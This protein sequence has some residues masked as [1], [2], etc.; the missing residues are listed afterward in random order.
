[1]FPLSSKQYLELLGLFFTT[2]CIVRE[3]FRLG[4]NVWQSELNVIGWHKDTFQHIETTLHF[5]VSS[6]SFLQEVSLL[7]VFAEDTGLRIRHT[8]LFE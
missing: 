2:C 7:K 5:L 3:S 8:L 1:M 6:T 4:Q